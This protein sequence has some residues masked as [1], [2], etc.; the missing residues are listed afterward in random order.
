MIQQIVVSGLGGQGILFIS[1]VL[2]EAAL[3]KGLSVVMSETHGM[4]QRGGNVISHIKVFRRKKPDGETSAAGAKV[5]V[6][7]LIRPGH[8]DVL[9]AL[10]QEGAQVHG[11]FLKPQG[12]LFCNRAPRENPDDID[13]AGIAHDLG[14]PV[15][16][17]L[18]LLGFAAATGKLFC[19][20]ENIRKAL[21]K[22]GGNRLSRNFEALEAGAEAHG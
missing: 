1:K 12:V 14:N 18:V 13:A 17:N 2:G 8:A 15:A 6:S 11:H 5:W 10:H 21:Q 16:A 22:I 9:L 7:P 20:T 19:S 4:A 3:I